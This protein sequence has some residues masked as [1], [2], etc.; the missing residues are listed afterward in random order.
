MSILIV[1]AQGSM[2]KRYQCILNYLEKPFE[3]VDQYDELRDIK[4]IAQ[5][6]SGII[7]ATPTDTHVK[8]IREFLPYQKPILC[9]KPI[10]KDISE[11]KALQDEITES[12]TPFRMMFQY[13]ILA[14]TNRLGA[15]RYNYFRHGNDGL[16]WDCLQ[17]IGLARG[18]IKLA[19]TSPVWSCGINGKTLNLAHMD[20]AYIA[21]VQR[22]FF[23]PDDSLLKILQVHEKTAEYNNGF[24]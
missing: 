17:I 15:S 22:W 24:Y 6:S 4:K 5:R 16:V 2:G 10:T 3:C 7:I 13:E 9:E 23:K 12:K 1:G 11:L 18:E 14:D 8:Y 20:A 19:E 21:Y